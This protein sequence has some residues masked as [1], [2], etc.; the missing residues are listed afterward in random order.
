MTRTDDWGWLKRLLA[1]APGERMRDHY[2]T[3][4]QELVR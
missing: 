4:I 1:K 3:S 2:S